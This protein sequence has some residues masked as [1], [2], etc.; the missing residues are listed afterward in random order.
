MTR[1]SWLL[2][3]KSRADLTQPQQVVLTT[4]PVPPFSGL[5]EEN[6]STWL[7]RFEAQIYREVSDHPP[8]MRGI[9]SCIRLEQWCR[10][11]ARDFYRSLPN[12]VQNDY[13]T[14][15]EE[16]R[17]RFGMQTY[18][19]NYLTFTERIRNAGRALLGAPLAGQLASSN[20]D[21]GARRASS[22]GLEKT[23]FPTL[24][25]PNSDGTPNASTLAD[26]T[27]LLDRSKENE[28]PAN[29]SAIQDAGQT[30]SGTTKPSSDEN[31]SGTSPE[32]IDS[33]SKEHGAA[34]W[35]P[36]PNLQVTI[37]PFGRDLVPPQEAAQPELPYYDDAC[38]PQES[39]N[40]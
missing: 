14:L 36:R 24:R 27:P 30:S 26:S 25:R 9:V 1:P 19:R 28:S 13:P 20:G 6:W 16:F 7:T 40:E 31:G 29:S 37:P 35:S 11:E 21:V 5:P 10:G 15:I 39:G 8:P 22:A 12:S 32:S 38:F 2:R 23:T 4:M 34:P 18:H 3:S 33:I 17:W